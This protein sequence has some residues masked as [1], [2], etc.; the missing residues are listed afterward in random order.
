MTADSVECMRCHAD[1]EVGFVPDFT[2]GG[3]VQQKWSPGEPRKSFW[4][5]LKINR[6]QLIPVTTY[7]CPKCGCLESYA[8]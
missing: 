8:K 5:W 1:M 7:R 2:Y 4:G 6:H 3:Y